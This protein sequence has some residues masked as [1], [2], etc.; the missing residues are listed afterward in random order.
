M[1]A[2]KKK[3]KIKLKSKKKKKFFFFNNKQI[4]QKHSQSISSNRVI[5]NKSKTLK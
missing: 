1:N 3:D 2:N 5:F 4:N